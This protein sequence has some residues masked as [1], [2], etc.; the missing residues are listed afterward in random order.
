MADEFHNRD[1]PC[2]RI[3]PNGQ[4]YTSLPSVS[5]ICSVVDSET[6]LALANWDTY[7]NRSFDSWN[8]INGGT[9]TPLI[10]KKAYRL[11]RTHRNIDILFPYLA[12]FLSEYMLAAELV[13]FLKT[14]GEVLLFHHRRD[15]PKLTKLLARDAENQVQ[16]ASSGR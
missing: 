10:A 14:R 13:K 11:M 6:A 15:P 5:Q 2:A 9:Y 7:I 3:V 1:F 12:I 16:K 4:G 8:D